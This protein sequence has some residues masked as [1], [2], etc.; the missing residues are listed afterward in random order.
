MSKCNNTPIF[1]LKYL[2]EYKYI[3]TLN[4]YVEKLD[5]NA[6]GRIV[7]KLLQY[8]CGTCYMNDLSNTERDKLLGSKEPRA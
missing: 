4:L 1:R 5:M 3:L 8:L 6:H 2:V 7:A